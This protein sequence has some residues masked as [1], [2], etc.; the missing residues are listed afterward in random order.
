MIFHL[1][2]VRLYLAAAIAIFEALLIT[3]LTGDRNS[4]AI[5]AVSVVDSTRIADEFRDRIR[6]PEVPAFFR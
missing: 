3:R 4:S 1:F 5:Q 6:L 2:L